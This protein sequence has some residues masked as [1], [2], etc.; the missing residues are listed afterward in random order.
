LP[1]GQIDPEAVAATNHP[2]NLSPELAEAHTWTPDAVSSGKIAIRTS[3]DPVGAHLAE[4][5]RA[6]EAAAEFRKTVDLKPDSTAV[7]VS[8]A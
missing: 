1:I 8:L 4:T 5:G 3:S 7:R 2:P 6:G